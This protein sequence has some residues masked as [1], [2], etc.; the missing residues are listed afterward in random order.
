MAA[1][2]NDGSNPKGTGGS[3]TFSGGYEIGYGRPPKHTQFKKGT[4]PNPRGRGK[5]LTPAPAEIVLTHGDNDEVGES[6]AGC[7]VTGHARRG[8]AARVSNDCNGGKADI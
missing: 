3:A 6:W 4:C 7:V 8:A 2:M 5:Q 1:A